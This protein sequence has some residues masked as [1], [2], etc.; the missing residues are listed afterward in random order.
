MGYIGIY[1]LDALDLVPAHSLTDHHSHF[2]SNLAIFINEIKKS[3]EREREL[4]IIITH[5]M[6]RLYAE[7]TL[8]LFSGAGYNTDRQTKTQTH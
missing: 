7:G 5:L 3:G 4:D 8:C 1:G 2:A 6:K